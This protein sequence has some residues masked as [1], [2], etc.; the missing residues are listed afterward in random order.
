MKKYLFTLL[1]IFGIAAHVSAQD[2]A[3]YIQPA[4]ALPGQNVTL[5]VC[6]KNTTEPAT[7]Q[8]SIEIPEGASF[9]SRQ[10]SWTR[11]P[12]AS[13][14]VFGWNA[15]ENVATALLYGGDKNEETGSQ[16]VFTGNDGE[17]CTITVKAPTALGEYKIKLTNIE[18]DAPDGTQIFVQK[19]DVS[20]F[21]LTVSNTVTLDENA[22][23]APAAAEGVNVKVLRT[24]NA[25]EWSTICLPFAMTKA[26]VADAFGD[27]VELAN[28]TGI[29]THLDTD[30]ETVIGITVN[31]ES[32]VDALEVDHPYIEA[33]HPYII[34]V[35]NA[36]SEILA[37]NVNIAAEE[38]SVD[39]DEFVVG[40]GKTATYFYNSFIGNYVAGTEVPENTLFLN[41]GKFY[42]SKGNNTIKAFRGYFDFYDVLTEVEGPVKAFISID[43][44]ADGVVEL[45]NNVKTNGAIFNLAGQRVSKAQ[46]GIFIQNGK[47]TVIK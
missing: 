25:N 16:Y 10:M 47:K 13:N 35:Q 15:V 39:C 34:K 11:I 9:V 2:N 19:E 32:V 14:K 33:N 5:S 30:L 8:F 43:G 18:L 45:K 42:Y 20:E 29:V 3:V 37:D 22:T 1:A 38:A 21:T 46:K 27:N 24:I 6:V 4:T 44:V 41:G 28:F 26:Q 7:V 31:F 36:V 23:E 40:K 12:E 17:V